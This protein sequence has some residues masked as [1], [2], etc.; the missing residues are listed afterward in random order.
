MSYSE[1]VVPLVKAV[2]EL[3]K[4]Q[5]SLIAVIATLKGGGQ[6][7]NNSNNDEQ[8]KNIQ[9]IKLNFPDAISMS[10]ARPN[11]NNKKAEIDYY[12]PSSVSNAQMLFTDMIGRVVNETKLQAGYGTISVDTKDLPVGTY[13]F[14]L[15][16]NE[17][18]VDTKK[19][20]R[21]K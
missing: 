16:V 18:V 3:S 2:Q 13:S 14:S 6:R 11:P 19:M 9:D 21:S 8:G 7:I 5:D 4:R 15:V 10:E 17:K 20:I 12:L 1:F